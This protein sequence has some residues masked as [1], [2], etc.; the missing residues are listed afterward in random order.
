MWLIVDRLSLGL[1]G[2]GLG[3]TG[4]RGSGVREDEKAF[5]R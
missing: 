3:F 2:L 5:Q 1:I 4:I